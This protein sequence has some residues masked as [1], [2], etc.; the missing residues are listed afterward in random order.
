MG[1]EPTTFCMAIVCEFRIN[2]CQ[3]GFRTNPITGDYARFGRCWSLN[4]PPSDLGLDI[5]LRVAGVLAAADSREPTTFSW[6]TNAP[7]RSSV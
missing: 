3:S 2:A 5:Q 6:Q 7:R 4:G 1:L